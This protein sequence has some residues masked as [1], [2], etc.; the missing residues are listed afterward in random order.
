MT[1]QNRLYHSSSV[2]NQIMYGDSYEP[3]FIKFFRLNH[4]GASH[5]HGRMLLIP[6][7]G[8]Q[9]SPFNITQRERERESQCYLARE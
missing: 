4:L 3:F 9:V 8:R 1:I 5:S 2:T 6:T 7:I